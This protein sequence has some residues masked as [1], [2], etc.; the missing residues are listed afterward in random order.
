MSALHPIADFTLRELELN[1]LLGYLPW[2]LVH[3][4]LIRPEYPKI[5]DGEF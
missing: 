4:R 3:C 5:N 1:F 2:L